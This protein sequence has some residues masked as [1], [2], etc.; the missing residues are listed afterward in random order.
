MLV[1]YM[2]V[3]KADGSQRSNCSATRCSLP[4]LAL[5][6]SMTI[7]LLDGQTTAPVLVPA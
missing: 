4:E 5:R 7:M 1:G 2:R 6:S 3:S